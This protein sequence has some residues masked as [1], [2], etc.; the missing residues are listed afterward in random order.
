MGGGIWGRQDRPENR[1]ETA[2][3]FFDGTGCTLDDLVCMRDKSASD[4][5]EAS[6]EREIH[7]QSIA[8]D[9]F[10]TGNSFSQWYNLL[11]A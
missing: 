9:L 4:I 2:S 8:L 3:V 10:N 1:T 11:K 6:K 7:K 5:F